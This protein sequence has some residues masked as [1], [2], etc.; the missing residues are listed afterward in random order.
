MLARLTAFA[1][2]AATIA[3]PAFAGDGALSQ[4]YRSMSENGAA[5]ESRAEAVMAGEASRQDLEALLAHFS[6]TA[7]KA[8]EA[9]D[10]HDGPKDLGCIYRGMAA[11]AKLQADRLK[12]GA[13]AKD[14]IKTVAA[15]GS[16]AVLV[17]PEPE[18]KAA[19][20][21]PYAGLPMS[22]PMAEG[23]MSAAQLSAYF[24]EQP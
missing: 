14:A 6:I 15:L 9:I 10:T 23:E 17:T 5:L 7:A 24:T 22:C 20:E 11:D 4:A 8:G 2:I 16:D 19:G 13:Q 21:D 1:I 18:T 12:D 3:A